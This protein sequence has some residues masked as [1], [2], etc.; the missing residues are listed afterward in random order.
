MM[1][2]VK[3]VNKKLPKSRIIKWTIRE[4]IVIDL[5]FI[6]NVNLLKKWHKMGR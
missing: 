2:N 3:M 1:A 5:K 6:I 4:S